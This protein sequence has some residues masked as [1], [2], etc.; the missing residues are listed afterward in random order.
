MAGQ[1][2]SQDASPCTR[3]TKRLTTCKKVGILSLLQPGQVP[4]LERT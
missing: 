1:Q 4:Q 3:C 2:L